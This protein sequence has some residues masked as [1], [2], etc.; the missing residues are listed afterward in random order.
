MRMAKLAKGDRL[1][2]IYG[3]APP[4]LDDPRITPEGKQ[5]ATLGAR[6]SLPFFRVQIAQRPSNHVSASESD[7]SP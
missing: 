6:P 4:Y 3:L 7:M 1:C 5:P 2:V